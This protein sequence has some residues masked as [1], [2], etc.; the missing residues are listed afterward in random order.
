MGKKRGVIAE[1][2]RQIKASQRRSEQAAR[3]RER[4]AAKAQREAEKAQRDAERAYNQARQSDIKAREAA[5]KA[6]EKALK[7]ARIA[8]VG[9]MNATLAETYDAIDSLLDQTLDVD[10]WVD[11]EAMRIS[12]VEHPTFEADGLEYEEAPV[13]DPIYPD[14]PQYV[15]P[16]E[17]TGVAAKFGGLKRHAQVVENA[18]ASYEKAS[19]SW[20]ETATRMYEEYQ[21]KIAQREDREV[22]RKARLQQ[23]LDTYGEECFR[24]EMEAREFN[25]TLDALISG[26]AYD[27]AS[28]IEE[29]IGIV[30]SNSIYPEVFPV[31]HEYTFD[32]STRELTLAAMI[33]S[34]SA[35]PSVKAY[36]Y[37]ASRNEVEASSLSQSQQ[38]ARYNTAVWNV[39]VRT[40]HE[41]FE[42]DRLGKIH[43]ISLTVQTEDTN[44]ATGRVEKFVLLA[45]AVPRDDFINIDLTNAVPTATLDMFK[46]SRSKNPFALVPAKTT[47]ATIRGGA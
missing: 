2:N 46:A 34:P 40:I 16:P 43:T 11:L 14:Q 22:A 10:D 45:V 27:S 7:E 18:R 19:A 4:A 28:A 21:Q 26:L 1:I 37:V 9:A 20:H 36:K 24:R 15:E 42:A 38:K 6:A 13:P 31:N 32:L 41:V 35:V 39:G 29:Y 25:D 5:Y 23:A 17:P 33:P 12:N 44:P 8:E 3:E 47:G 30:L